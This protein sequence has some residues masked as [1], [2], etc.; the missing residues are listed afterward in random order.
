MR[1]AADYLESWL[2]GKQSIQ[3]RPKATYLRPRTLAEIIAA[4]V[5]VPEFSSSTWQDFV[6][7]YAQSLK[8]KATAPK[9]KAVKVPPMNPDGV[10]ELS[11]AD[12]EISG[13]SALL[14]SFSDG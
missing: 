10:L 9:P 1:K 3:P 6:S 11:S 5:H 13:V 2:D 8:V 14:S 4:D 7:P 12:S